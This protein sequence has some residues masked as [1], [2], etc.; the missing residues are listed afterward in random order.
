MLFVMSC[1]RTTPNLFLVASLAI[2]AGLTSCG[3]AP[4]TPAATTSTAT[5]ASA[6]P[7]T[8]AAGDIT[9]PNQVVSRS[10]F[11]KAAAQIQDGV[12]TKKDLV[13]KLGLF[14]KK[15]TDA[16][17]K[18]TAI[19]TFKQSKSTAKAFIPGSAFIPGAVVTYYQTLSVVLDANEVVIS[20]AFSESTQEKT[21]LGFSYGS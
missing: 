7:A 3:T 5:T 11:S 21:G 19:W 6:A 14:Y 8:N 10:H 9:D 16:S 15:G 17:G 20:H 2:T 12:T 18:A 1:M 13:R 4:E